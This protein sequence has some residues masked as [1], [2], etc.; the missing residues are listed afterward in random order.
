MAD[1]TW[2]VPP[3]ATP[4][5]GSDP[6]VGLDATVVDFWRLAMSDLSMNN[7]RGYLA[8]FLVAKA[9]GLHDVVRVE[10]DAYDLLLDKIQI[11]V[12]SSSYLQ[13]WEQPRPSRIV[14]TG[15]RGTRY[16]PRHGY[17]PDGK[18]LN[19]HVYVFSV[20]TAITHNE[21]RPLDISQ[22]SF[23]VVKRSAL[24]R[25]RTA[26]VGLDTVVR[27]AGGATVWSELRSTV[28]QVAEGEEI[29]DAPWWLKP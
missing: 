18:R 12:K 9:L 8:E 28:F 13:A 11:E 6:F 22:W 10:W 3:Q 2:I 1:E 19:A 23:Y 14:F 29:D 27:L 4:I 17:D 20:Q 16:H 15:L 26:S 24:E 25:Q 5:H 21:Y 7:T